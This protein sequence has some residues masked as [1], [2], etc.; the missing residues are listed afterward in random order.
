MGL[1][2]STA[3]PHPGNSAQGGGGSSSGKLKFCLFPTEHGKCTDGHHTEKPLSKSHAGPPGE[4]PLAAHVAWHSLEG[5]APGPL[6]GHIRP[7]LG[8]QE[9]A[10]TSL[11]STSLFLSACLMTILALTGS[12]GMSQ[13]AGPWA[14]TERAPRQPQQIL[15]HV[16]P[17]VSFNP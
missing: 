9:R 14:C 12:E 10:S 17:A 16:A 2:V 8:L 11:E 5:V 13:C 1:P 6:P 7:P 4:M 15:K 3:G